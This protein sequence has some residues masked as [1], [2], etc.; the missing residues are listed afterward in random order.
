MSG[1]SR[2]FLE[3]KEWHTAWRALDVR[4]RVRIA[5]AVNHGRAVAEPRHAWVAVFLAKTNRRTARLVGRLW[6]VLET[7][8]TVAYV[9]RHYWVLAAGHAVVLALCALGLLVIPWSP[10]RLARAEA[11]NRELMEGGATARVSQ[12]QA[13]DR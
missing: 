11:L 6:L 2:S 4:T 5:Y 13:E 10:S 7:A 8:Q 1:P 12:A 3:R 9:V